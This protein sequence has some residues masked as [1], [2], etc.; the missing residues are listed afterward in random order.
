MRSLGTPLRTQGAYPATLTAD[1][2]EIIKASYH[3]PGSPDRPGTRA[4][5]SG[6]LVRA[7]STAFY[8]LPLET[9]S[10]QANFY[11]CDFMRDAQLYIVS[12]TISTITTLRIK[13]FG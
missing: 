11:V 4:T 3:G 9:G 2:C 7:D 5:S 8:Q 1:A 12:N 6:R 10:I 13:N